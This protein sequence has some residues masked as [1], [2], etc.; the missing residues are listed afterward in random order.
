VHSHGDK[1]LVVTD[2]WAPCRLIVWQ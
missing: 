1:F 2:S